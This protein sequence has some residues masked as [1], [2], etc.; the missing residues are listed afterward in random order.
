MR[1]FV[2]VDLDARLRAAAADLVA[3][4]QARAARAAPQA[5]IAWS[6][7]EG[8]H[9]TLRFLG[10]VDAGRARQVLDVLA[11]D[12]S[13]EAFEMTLAGAGTFPPQGPPRVIW[14]GVTGGRE[15]MIALEQDVSA[16]LALVGFPPEARPY[17]PHLTLARVRDPAGLRAPALFGP[18]ADV[19]LGATWVDAITLYESR[20][21]PS[22]AVHVPL[23]RAR[24]GGR[25]ARE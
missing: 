18:A 21:T 6:A 10:D 8:L 19:Q 15:S 22:R 1:L 17:T 20:L 23:L 4:W 13:R 16:R 25:R 3:R 14:V 2:A 9:V 24:L 12:V 7:P 11:P 5:R